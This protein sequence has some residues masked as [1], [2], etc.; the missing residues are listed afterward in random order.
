MRT[1]AITLALFGSATLLLALA[2]LDRGTISGQPPDARSSRAILNRGELSHTRI[3][4]ARKTKTGR[5]IVILG[6][7]GTGVTEVTHNRSINL[8]PSWSRDGRELIFTSY[9]VWHKYLTVGGA[10]GGEESGS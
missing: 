4:A 2:L 6:I 8:L 10:Q 5:E 3:A 9:L 7:D 1:N